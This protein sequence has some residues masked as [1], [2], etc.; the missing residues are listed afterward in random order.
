MP[1]AQ[2]NGCGNLV[3]SVYRDLASCPETQPILSDLNNNHIQ[4][5]CD[6]NLKEKFIIGPDRIS[7]PA[8]FPP[9]PLVLTAYKTLLTARTQKEFENKACAYEAEKYADLKIRINY[10]INKEVQR[11]TDN[12]LPCISPPPEGIDT[13]IAPDTYE[14]FVSTPEAFNLKREHVERHNQ[15]CDRSL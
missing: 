3:E 5:T 15:R 8:D 12:C 2:D 13:R 9:F 7:L 11:I 14:E 1:S 10:E 4:I 6:P